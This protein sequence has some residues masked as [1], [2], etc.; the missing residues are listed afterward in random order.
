MITPDIA[1][2]F[3][4]VSPIEATSSAIPPKRKA[5]ALSS[6][7][8]AKRVK[9]KAPAPSTQKSVVAFT[10][11][12]LLVDATAAPTPSTDMDPNDQGGDSSPT[13]STPMP[14]KNVGV[15]PTLEGSIVADTPQPDVDA[16]S[17]GP[18]ISSSNHGI[19]SKPAIVH[20]VPPVDVYTLVPGESLLTTVFC[21]VPSAFYAR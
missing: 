7:A 3:S 16:V 10:V 21:V 20:P 14:A 18:V 1:R 9:T 17:V 6:V 2:V 12:V 4:S 15:T 13:P 5:K 8:L 11:M 19:E